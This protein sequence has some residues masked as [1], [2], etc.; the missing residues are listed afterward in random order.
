[1]IEKYIGKVICNDNIETLKKFPKGSIDCVVTSPP[2]DDL[3]DYK[4]YNFEHEDLANQLFR[5]TKDGGVVVWVIRDAVKNGDRT[6]S[7]YRQ[8][9][10]FQEIGFNVYDVVIF[11]KKSST[12]PHE[13][14]FPDVFE[15]MYIFSK[16]LPKTVNLIKDRKNKY[17]GTTL[18]GDRTVREKDGE[19]SVRKPRKV[20]QYGTRGNI[21]DYS[22][23]FNNSTTDKRA[24]D[25][26]ATFPEKLARDH[27]YVWTNEGDIVLDPFCGSGT[28]P[29]MAYLMNRNYI[30]IDISEKYCKI[31]RKRLL[32]Y[33][34]KQKPQ[35]Y[36]DKILNPAKYVKDHSI[37]R[38]FK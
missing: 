35:S 11:A 5:V 24:F 18:Y 26:P 10:H 6:L 29:K 3:R 7:S 38:F 21:W 36:W 17:A 8:A 27:I 9:I 20:R 14:R 34:G 25:H 31:A 1:M 22:I 2:Y 4:G 32:K 33:E 37:N 13:N 16:G 23:G 30:G 28:T 15:Y 12:L 19:L